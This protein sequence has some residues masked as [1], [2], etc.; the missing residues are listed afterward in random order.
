MELDQRLQ[1][2]GIVRPYLPVPPQGK[3]RVSLLH[4]SPSSVRPRSIAA[5]EVP[6]TEGTLPTSDGLLLPAWS[7]EAIVEW[8]PLEASAHSKLC[9]TAF[10]VELARRL[11]AAAAPVRCHMLDPGRLRT[12]M[13][14]KALGL[15]KTQRR[16]D[17]AWATRYGLE[18]DEAAEALMEVA[19]GEEFGRGNGLYVRLYGGSPIVENPS[20]SLAGSLRGAGSCMSSYSRVAEHPT[21]A[22]TAVVPGRRLWDLTADMVGYSFQDEYKVL[23][24]F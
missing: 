3:I 10:T 1:F 9:L 17:T 11:D 24:A 20:D 16:L 5:L 8:S 23:L 12:P 14:R 7:R 2:E 19:R 13:W 15:S 4:T 18:A 6:T 21:S 22:A